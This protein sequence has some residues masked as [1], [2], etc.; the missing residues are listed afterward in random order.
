MF[1]HADTRLPENADRLVLD[2]L[3]HSRRAWGRF[4][5]RI[6]GRHPALPMIAAMMNL[7]SRLT[8]IATG[9]QAIFVRVAAFAATGGYPDIALMED[10]VLS[11]R[12]KKL[13]AP[14]C[15]AAKALTSGR[16]WEKYGVMRT[17][18][19]MWRLRLA[20]FFGA[21]PAELA[22]RYGYVP[23]QS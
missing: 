7:R 21:E 8:G 9:D 15:L 6:D 11:R 18:L 3:D 12:L 14:L 17:V 10:I 16:R 5:V 20:F 23:R 13:S 1:L 2:G 19:T 22:A 4:D